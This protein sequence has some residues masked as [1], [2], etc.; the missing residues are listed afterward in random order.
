MKIGPS[1]TP[2]SFKIGFVILHNRLKQY[3]ICTY[4]MCIKLSESY[5]IF[6]HVSFSYAATAVMLEVPLRL[7]KFRQMKEKLFSVLA[8]V[9]LS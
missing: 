4:G 7:V 1:F 2:F 6:I 3:N 5:L 8:D 9:L